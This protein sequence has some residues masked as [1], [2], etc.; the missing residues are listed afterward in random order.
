MKCCVY[1]LYSESYKQF[2]VGIT[3][4]LEDRLRRHNNGESRSTKKGLPWIL[5]HVIECVDK[6][7]AMELETRIKKE[8]SA[9]TLQ[10]II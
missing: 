8:V 4:N 6:S 5:L 3:N 10:I 9:A 7:A 1:F 2:Y